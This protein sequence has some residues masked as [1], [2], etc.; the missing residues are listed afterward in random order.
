[1]IFDLKINLFS[2]LLDFGGITTAYPSPGY[3]RSPYKNA[4][5]GEAID[6]MQ[7]GID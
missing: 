6:C 3:W 7:S 5:T 4:L 1:M 2:H